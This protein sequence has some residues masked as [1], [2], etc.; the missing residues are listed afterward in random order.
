MSDIKKYTN[1][2]LHQIIS[3]WTRCEDIRVFIIK[4]KN[5]SI[6]RF[7]IERIICLFK[8][9]LHLVRTAKKN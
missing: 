1:E 7:N 9:Q 2:E 8:L 3:K 4:R 5:N 6:F